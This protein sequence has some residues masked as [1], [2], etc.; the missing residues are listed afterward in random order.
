MNSI[1]E[2]LRPWL[3]QL[4]LV[5]AVKEDVVGPTCDHEHLNPIEYVRRCIPDF[6]KAIEDSI[7]GGELKLPQGQID[8]LA[9]LAAE[10]MCEIRRLAEL[11]RQKR[12]TKEFIRQTA[13]YPSYRDYFEKS[14]RVVNLAIEIAIHF[15]KGN[16]PPDP[17]RN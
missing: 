17:A 14:P 13:L 2:N 7:R 16:K 6:R 1:P 10:E 4:I 15:A 11:L 5:N 3:S 9:R 12:M 8:D